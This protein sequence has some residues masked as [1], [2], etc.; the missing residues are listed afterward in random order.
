MQER[1]EIYRGRRAAVLGLGRSGAA[2]ARL[3]AK[4]GAQVVGFDENVRVDA[5][6]IESVE[7]RRGPDECAEIDGFDLIVTSPGIDPRTQLWRAALASRTPIIGEIELA[8]SL[9]KVP[10]VAITGTNG[11]STTTELTA[12]ALIACGIRTVA[13]GNIGLPYSDV[14]ASSESYDFITLEI[15]S[16]QVETI[17]SFRPHVAAWL[18]FAPDHLDRYIDM[19]D[20]KAA[21]L[22]VFDYQLPEDFAVLN[23]TAK[24]PGLVA[25]R[26][27]F[28]ADR[29]AD[30]IL[31]Q[32]SLRFRG[33]HVLNQAETRLPGPHNAENMLACLGIVQALGLSLSSAAEALRA[34]A[35][36]AHRCELVRELRGVR[37]VNDSKATNLDSMEK[38]LLA[39]PGGIV[40]IVGGKDKG[41]DYSQ[42]RSLVGQRVKRAILMGDIAPKI[43]EAWSDALPCERAGHSLAEAVRLATAA[44]ATG[45]TVLLSPGTSSFDMFRDYADRGDQ[46]RAFVEALT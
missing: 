33:E 2:A 22:H 26:L 17:R 12:A 39:Q 15:S 40:L 14:V 21:K 9:S 29:E 6:N 45:D 35:P 36:L 46:F 37:F 10:V 20:Y 23:A 5:P 1:T 30:L 24:I 7:T 32:G 11:K 34:Y 41:I 8:W 43:E 3:L 38:A 27:T 25:A 19:S 16:F 31:E 4:Y 44:A 42:V 13:A 28:S 18:N